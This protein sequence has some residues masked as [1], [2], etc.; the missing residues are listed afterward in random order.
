MRAVDCKPCPPSVSAPCLSAF[1]APPALLFL[2]VHARPMSTQNKLLYQI[3]LSIAIF[4]SAKFEEFFLWHG[5]KNPA[6][7]TNLMRSSFNTVYS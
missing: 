4:L 5:I 3:L 1:L 7:S 6:L 2:S